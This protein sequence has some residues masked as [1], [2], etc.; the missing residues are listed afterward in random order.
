[1]SL[2]VCLI[3]IIIEQYILIIVRNT[4]LSMDQLMKMSIPRIFAHLSER[5]LML[6]IPNLYV[7]L[8]LFLALFHHWMNL[9]AELTRF[10]DR[11]FYRDWWNSSGFEEYWRKWNLPIHNFINRHINK[12][13]LRAGESDGCVYAWVLECFT[14]LCFVLQ[15]V[16]QQ[17]WRSLSPFNCMLCDAVSLF[18]L[19][20]ECFD[21]HF[22]G[23]TSKRLFVLLLRRS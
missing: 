13:L 1:M 20:W 19:I 18:Q 6:S 4:F 16:S 15:W 22:T 21:T 2:S 17:L 9:L 10:G 14:Q 11:N 7:W 23:L 5:I 8:L 3:R 12:P